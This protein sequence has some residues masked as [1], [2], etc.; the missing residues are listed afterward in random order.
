MIAVHICVHDRFK[1]FFQQKDHLKTEYYVDY[2]TREQLLTLMDE[3]HY[4]VVELVPDCIS[5]PKN[6]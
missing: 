6:D 3:A 1:G 4:V 5:I 2:P